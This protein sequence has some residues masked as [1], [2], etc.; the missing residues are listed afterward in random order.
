MP[1]K[2]DDK[3]PAAKPAAPPGWNFDI[4]EGAIVLLII[5]AIVGTLIP[6]IWNGASSGKITF[7][8]LKFSSMIDYIGSI[9]YI[10]KG[11]GFGL[12]GAGAVATFVFNK[13]SDKI[14]AD[15]KAKLY[16]QEMEM[17]A[18]DENQEI[19]EN[20]MIG[21]W[22]Q[23][24]AHS[25]SQVP[26]DWRLCIIEADIILEELLDTLKLPGD[27]I[28][29]KLKAVEKSDFLT[30]ESAWEAHKVR[31]QIAHEGSNFLLNQREARRV[32]SLYEAVF[33]EFHII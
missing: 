22:K 20:P 19:I 24:V 10:F 16:P 6:A 17:D 2:K 30:I 32:I 11:I 25:E 26:S 31:N 4:T 8:G 7:F 1:P 9:S 13:R 21:R 23:I 29:E 33:K 27:T 14:W 18:N 3:K 12:A 15:E 28:G 5:L